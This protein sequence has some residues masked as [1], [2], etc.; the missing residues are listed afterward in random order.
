[1]TPYE[2]FS[3]YRNLDVRLSDYR[4]IYGLDIHEYRNASLGGDFSVAGGEKAFKDL[5]KKIGEF[6]Q[7]AGY[8]RYLINYPIISK[9]EYAKTPYV[10]AWQEYV[11]TYPDLY[12]VYMGKGSLVQIE[13]ALRLAVAFGLVKDNK[14]DLQRYCDKNIG[15]DCSGFARNYFNGDFKTIENF[16]AQNKLT[17]LSLVRTGTAII[18][19]SLS[20]IALVDKVTKVERTGNTVYAV[21]CMVAESTGDRMLRDG[22]KDGLNYTEY[23]ILYEKPG[24]VFEAFRSIAKRRGFYKP[25]VY[26]VNK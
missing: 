22:P 18:W 24:N 11:V 14:S 16:A 8:K 5:Q 25:K 2:L 26:L 15:L 7:P 4:M 3:K 21:E 1:M 19:K 9:K 13:Q 17:D 10:P 20:H 12:E 6:G 23:T